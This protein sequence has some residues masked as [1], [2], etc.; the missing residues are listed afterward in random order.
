MATATNPPACSICAKPFGHVLPRTLYGFPVC[1]ED[2]QSFMVKRVVAHLIDAVLYSIFFA[3]IFWG[4]LIVGAI[5][6]GVTTQGSDPATVDRGADTLARVWLL[7][8]PA[9]MLGRTLVDGFRGHS[10]GKAMLGLQ[11]IEESDG[12]PA[13]FWD[14]FQRNLVILVP[15]MPI[16]I[17]ALL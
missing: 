6:F 9:G 15:F 1:P 4:F 11:V 7:L 2:Y 17:L 16:I 13:N 12:R 3:I 14:S 10:P 8:I 5:V